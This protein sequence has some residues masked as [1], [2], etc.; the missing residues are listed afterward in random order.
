MRIGTGSLF[1]F[2][3][4]DRVFGY[5]IK[6]KDCLTDPILP[7]GFVS[8]YVGDA[9]TWR[10][11]L[12]AASVSCAPGFDV[13]DSVVQT[14]RSVVCVNGEWTKSTLQCLKTCEPYVELGGGSYTVKV[15]NDDGST[16]NENN[17][18]II[19]EHIS[20][21]GTRRKVSCNKGYGDAAGILEQTIVCSNGDW[22][23]LRLD[24][25]TN[26]GS[27]DHILKDYPDLRVVATN[28]GYEGST[29]DSPKASIELACVAGKGPVGGKATSKIHCIGGEW[30]S[31]E[32]RCGALCPP[33]AEFKFFQSQVVDVNRYTVEWG[34]NSP[35]AATK[36]S[37]AESYSPLKRYDASK[38]ESG[39]VTQSSVKVFCLDGSF[40]DVDFQCRRNCPKF[41]TP[42]PSEAFKVLDDA[43]ASNEHGATR[44]LVCADGWSSTH[45]DIDRDTSVCVDGEW[46]VPELRCAPVCP[47]ARMAFIYCDYSNE[48]GACSAPYEIIW[49]GKYGNDTEPS[50]S[51]RDVTSVKPNV[52]L[53]VRCN[54]AA[55]YR[56]TDGSSN[57]WITTTCI[58]STSPSAGPEAFTVIG[59]ECEKS[60]L[61]GDLNLGP[62]YVVEARLPNGPMMYSPWMDLENAAVTSGWTPNVNATIA[63]NATSST[64]TT[65]LQQAHLDGKVNLSRWATRTHPSFQKHIEAMMANMAAS[66]HPEEVKKARALEKHLEQHGSL[67]VFLQP[68]NARRAIAPDMLSELNSLPKDKKMFSSAVKLGQLASRNARTLQSLFPSTHRKTMALGSRRPSVSSLSTLLQRASDEGMH[69]SFLQ[70]AMKSQLLPVSKIISEQLK[71]VK[72]VVDPAAQLLGCSNNY[73]MMEEIFPVHS[74]FASMT[75]D[76]LLTETRPESLDRMKEEMIAKY[77]KDVMAMYDHSALSKD[78]V[79]KATITDMLHRLQMFPDR[80]TFDPDEVSVGDMCK[81][82]CGAPFCPKTDGVAVRVTQVDNIALAL[83]G[84][85]KSSDCADYDALPAA[86]LPGSSCPYSTIMWLK[87]TKS[88]FDEATDEL[89]DMSF[90]DVMVQSGAYDPDLGELPIPDDVTF[91]KVCNF[92]C[93]D[94]NIKIEEPAKN[95]TLVDIEEEVI[96]WQEVDP[97]AEQPFFN[98][99]LPYGTQANVTCASGYSK[100][101]LTD[102]VSAQNRNGDLLTCIGATFSVRTMLCAKTCSKYV[103]PSSAFVATGPGTESK[104]VEYGKEVYL[105]CSEGSYGL[106]GVLTQTLTCID[107][108][109]T[110]RT[111]QCMRN[112][113]SAQLPVPGKLM[114]VFTDDESAPINL[115]N[116][117]SHGA[118]FAYG[119]LEKVDGETYHPVSLM[120]K[121]GDLPQSYI[122]PSRERVRCVDGSWSPLTIMCKRDCPFPTLPDLTRYRISLDPVSSSNENVQVYNEDG[123]L[124]TKSADPQEQAAL[125]AK[126]PLTHNSEYYVECSDKLSR[127]DG[128]PAGRDKIRCLDGRWTKQTLTC[129]FKCDEFFPRREDADVKRFAIE[130]AKKGID[131]AYPSVKVNHNEMR[132]VTCNSDVFFFPLDASIEQ[133][134]MTC[135]DGKWNLFHLQCRQACAPLV[136]S[137]SFSHNPLLHFPPVGFCIWDAT[138]KKCKLPPPGFIAH[139][140]TIDLSCADGFSPLSGKVPVTSSCLD[141]EWTALSVQCAPICKHETIVFGK[142]QE[143]KCFTK[144][145]VVIDFEGMEAMMTSNATNSKATSLLQQAAST[146]KTTTTTTTTKNKAPTTPTTTT[147]TKST[148]S[149]HPTNQKPLPIAPTLLENQPLYGDEGY[150]PTK[151]QVPEFSPKNVSDVPADFRKSIPSCNPT[152]KS[153]NWNRIQFEHGSEIAYQC[154]DGSDPWGVASISS[155]SDCIWGD[156]TNRGL[157]CKKRCPINALKQALLLRVNGEHYEVQNDDFVSGV[158]QMELFAKHDSTATVF[159]SQNSTVWPVPLDSNPT[160]RLTCMDGQWETPTILCMKACPEHPLVKESYRYQIEYQNGNSRSHASVAKVTCA[161]GTFPAIPFKNETQSSMCVN[162][163]WQPLAYPCIEGCALPS[164][165][166]KYYRAVRSE[167]DLL[168]Q[169]AVERQGVILY[170]AMQFTI[171]CLS[172]FTR[173][174]SFPSWGPMTPSPLKNSQQYSNLAVTCD[175]GAISD[176]VM[177]F[178]SCP[179]PETALK[180]LLKKIIIKPPVG[181]TKLW[182]DN[183]SNRTNEWA[184]ESTVEISCDN[185]NG[186]YNLDKEYIKPLPM[187]CRNGSWDVPRLHCRLKCPNFEQSDL[188]RALISRN[189]YNTYA[190]VPMYFLD[191]PS[192]QQSEVQ[193]P[194]AF[195]QAEYTLHGS[196]W[197]LE[198]QAGYTPVL[199]EKNAFNLT[200]VWQGDDVEEAKSSALSPVSSKIGGVGKWSSKSSRASAAAD[201]KNSVIALLGNATDSESTS[202]ASTNVRNFTRLAGRDEI[203]CVNGSWVGFE[204]VC[205]PKC[206]EFLHPGNKDAFSRGIQTP[207]YNVFKLSEIEFRKIE[208][209]SVTKASDPVKQSSST[210]SSNELVVTGTRRMITCAEGYSPVNVKGL[211]VNSDGK[212]F[213]AATCADG[214]WN[215]GSITCVKDCLEPYSVVLKRKCIEYHK[216]NSASPCISERSSDA[217]AE[218]QC[219]DDDEPNTP[220]KIFRTVIRD[221]VVPTSEDGSDIKKFIGP[222]AMRALTTH[223]ITCN[224]RLEYLPVMRSS[225]HIMNDVPDAGQAVV[226]TVVCMDGQWSALDLNCDK[227]CR[228][229]FDLYSSEKFWAP[230]YVGTVG[231]RYVNLL[232]RGINLS[233]LSNNF[234]QYFKSSSFYG[235]AP[236]AHKV[237]RLASMGLGGGIGAKNLRDRS[238][239][240]YPDWGWQI[241]GPGLCTPQDGWKGNADARCANQLKPRGSWV[242]FHNVGYYGR[243]YY[244]MCTPGGGS[245]YTTFH[246]DYSAATYTGASGGF[247][248]SKLN[249]DTSIPAHQM[250]WSDPRIPLVMYS[251]A[252]VSFPASYGNMAYPIETEEAK[253]KRLEEEAKKNGK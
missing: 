127:A 209:D 85:V 117:Y 42:S 194:V 201:Y 247:Y 159:C 246:Y 25:D 253:K 44:T 252:S 6:P 28:T 192:D 75:C 152:Q 2:L 113:D 81:L 72:P 203:K 103:P 236:A 121:K 21:S 170:H 100:T 234:K 162:G 111:L 94:C 33:Q 90:T 171:G 206:K 140:S 225:A 122:S 124:V 176:T 183:W 218:K 79:C 77:G 71:N 235:N 199:L 231:F 213:A 73:T 27:Y 3:S 136:P 200:M 251:G 146:K 46:T 105:S 98:A 76:V 166:N 143:P 53:E 112:C 244:S 104:N 55:G 210:E 107:G 150:I 164:G 134:T 233:F 178:R 242:L 34:G 32:I 54:E 15:M 214:M 197:H 168:L 37:C 130:P 232:S 35:G 174:V 205:V 161:A 245:L 193:G 84:L 188:G 80:Y 82:A 187:V 91:G 180:H 220:Y 148:K 207:P 13:A 153:K 56:P 96:T 119:C 241:Y 139:D 63:N 151:A 120:N 239:E 157:V 14:Q 52:N 250:D 93:G 135:N 212:Y 177:C 198:C 89:C 133:Q 67:S 62:A 109:W 47:L 114:E 65:L 1:F 60:C 66:K 156:W 190:R 18:E 169:R 182:R 116:R 179:H 149:N 58:G 49:S 195:G 126:I 175:S 223:V 57:Q 118:S 221:T 5:E 69:P 70:T 92:Q 229:T 128:P 173:G 68:F 191:K 41:Q 185:A 181:N 172:G 26:C 186:Y 102:D 11:H 144:A 39:L 222:M 10:K 216:T 125:L 115:S 123:E 165:V 4:I 108:E 50:M 22:T 217:C 215:V 97:F 240:M 131:S 160:Q 219:Q 17:D 99:L 202:T 184:H 36:V 243:Y 227:G 208:N 23:K 147:T 45:H 61:V 86:V 12:N 16:R 110:P 101:L 19:S 228:G 29:Q 59:R 211:D 30:E 7:V 237:K 141:G 154:K 189:T 20:R 138:N 38:P 226:S 167:D 106:G 74:M 224:S 142:N 155:T 9:T 204:M 249:Y 24:C 248:M 40:E 129:K 137:T 132:F 88:P 43:Q 83:A 158:H 8:Q 238:G 163:V 51:W 230:V 95:D 78:E 87:A 64:A 31:P 196:T 48:T 145:P